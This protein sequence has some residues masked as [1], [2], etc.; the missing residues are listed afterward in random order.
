MNNKCVFSCTTG[1]AKMGNN[2]KQKLTVHNI[3]KLV[4]F[5]SPYFTLYKIQ[6]IKFYLRCRQSKHLFQLLSYLEVLKIQVKSFHKI[7][8]LPHNGVRPRK[9]R[10]V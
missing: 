5:F 9:L 4:A 8:E 7:L 3:W 10:R 2:K 1:T 6:F